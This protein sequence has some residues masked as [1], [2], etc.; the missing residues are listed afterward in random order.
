MGAKRCRH[1]VSSGI[2]QQGLESQFDN[3]IGKQINWLSPFMKQ[4]TA[5]MELLGAA[6]EETKNI[7]DRVNIIMTD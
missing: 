2:P 6:P 3:Y 1:S 5:S 7:T 4:P